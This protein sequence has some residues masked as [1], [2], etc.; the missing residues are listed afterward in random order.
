MFPEA[1][2]AKLIRIQPT[3]WHKHISLRFELLGQTAAGASESNQGQPPANKV[4]AA[5]NGAGM[6]FVDSFHEHLISATCRGPIGKI[7]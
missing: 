6:L 2:R 5:N 3:H 1:I 7:I 4:A